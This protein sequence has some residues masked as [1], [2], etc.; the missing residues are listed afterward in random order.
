MNI[1]FNPEIKTI[2]NR[3]SNTAKHRPMA[4]SASIKTDTVSFKGKDEKPS[5]QK[6]K[7]NSFIDVIKVPFL[8]LVSFLN[9]I[10]D[11]LK[12]MFIAKEKE[13]KADDKDVKLKQEY[14]KLEANTIFHVLEKD[15]KPDLTNESRVEI[16]SKLAKAFSYVELSKAYGQVHKILTEKGHDDKNIHNAHEIMRE[17]SFIAQNAY[18]DSVKGEIKQHISVILDREIEKL[19]IFGEDKEVVIQAR[20]KMGDDH[21]FFDTILTTAFIDLKPEDNL[22]YECR[23]FINGWD[24]DDTN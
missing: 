15:L 24:Q 13:P 16:A 6:A 4:F 23:S 10:V 2:I 20:E 3:D 7:L 8:M 1:N 9:S 12:S 19:P 22:A 21:K 11:T 18:F 17:A 5:K 14:K